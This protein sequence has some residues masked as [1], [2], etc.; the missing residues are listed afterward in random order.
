MLCWRTRRRLRSALNCYDRLMFSR[1]HL[2]YDG[3]IMSYRYRRPVHVFTSV[4]FASIYQQ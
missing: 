3:S 4:Q 1:P 2:V